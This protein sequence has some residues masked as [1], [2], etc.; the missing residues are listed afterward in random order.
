YGG[1]G[2]KFTSNVKASPTPKTENDP[3]FGTVLTFWDNKVTFTRKFTVTDA[4][5]AE[6]TVKV[7]YMCCN[8]QSCRPPKQET[9]VVKVEK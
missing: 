8:D 4:S 3:Q 5:K 9:F 1:K 2:I 7:D 6:V